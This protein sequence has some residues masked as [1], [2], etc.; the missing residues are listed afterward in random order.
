MN[1]KHRRIFVCLMAVAA[2]S[3]A[4]ASANDKYRVADGQVVVVCPLTVGGSFEAKT[5]SVSGEV[6]VAPQPGGPLG[7]AI[8]VD[9]QTLQTGIG[10]RDRH[11][12]DNYLE[13]G[14]GPD[15]SKA[16]LEGIQIEKL[17]GKSTFRGTLV[18]HGE[19]RPV[20]GSAE[21]QQQGD[22]GYRVQAEFPVRVTDF[23]IAKP[24][25]LGVGVQEEVK[26]KIALTAV[27]AP[28]AT[29]GAKR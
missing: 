29:T 13:V 9:L 22:G 5:Q 11:M 16:T 18:L 8:S 25:Y 15:F 26:I 20:T 21:V 12:R 24:T 4:T 14:K 19:R 10:L 3:V 6:A 1:M 23:N 2:A 28:V 17:N 27:P 7:G